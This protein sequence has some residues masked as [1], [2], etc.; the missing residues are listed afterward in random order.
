VPA[1][2]TSRPLGVQP[3]V[4]LTDEQW[5]ALQR[6]QDY[7]LT[8]VPA[9]LLK[10]GVLPAEWVDDALFEFR[11]FLG[12]GIV[13]YTGL[14][15]VSGAVD[16]VWHTCILATR[17]YADLCTQTVGHFVH[18]EPLDEREPLEGEPTAA[19]E[20]LDAFRRFKQAYT[21]VYGETTRMWRFPILWWYPFA[22]RSR[23][24]GAVAGRG[25]RRAKT[26]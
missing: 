12:L 7:D 26:G 21:C 9:R 20:T 23:D 3:D 14:P 8:W 11:R 2:G 22:P 19:R 5:A 18:H 25:R 13:G 24:P 4:P 1:A 10:K 17:L 6:L 15:M 16:E